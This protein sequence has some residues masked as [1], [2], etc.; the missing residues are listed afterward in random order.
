MNWVWIV[1]LDILLIIVIALFM[2]VTVQARF[3]EKTELKIKYAGITVFSLQP[4]TEKDRK[5]ASEKAEKKKAEKAQKAAKKAE[6]KK[7]RKKAESEKSKKPKRTL[8]ENLELIR[9][10]VGSASR[11]IKRLFRHIRVTDVNADITVSGDDAAA[12]A[13]N[14]G[15]MCVLITSVLTVLDGAVRLSVDN[16]ELGVDFQSGRSV[17][18]IGLKVSL[19]IS[20]ALG[21]AVWFL[22]R[23]IK[24]HF[25]KK[26]A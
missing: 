22:F 15:K 4:Q 3:G 21:C 19:R 7:E 26:K 23:M 17:Y 1:L 9:D 6:E 10:L 2:S 25:F 14:Y 12:A 24:R 20:T 13:L 8:E 5:K 16:I 11:P 18:D